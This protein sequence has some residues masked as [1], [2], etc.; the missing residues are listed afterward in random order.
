MII[1]RVIHPCLLACS[2]I[3]A[4]TILPL[5]FSLPAS[6]AGQQIVVDYDWNVGP[7]NPD[8]SAPWMQAIITDITGGVQFDFI[9]LFSS[10][11]FVSEIAFNLV[12]DSPS[13]LST[14]TAACV[15][16]S[17]S[18]SCTTNTRFV[19]GQD[20]QTVNNFMGFDL[21]FF[22]PP[23]QGGPENTLGAPPDAVRF[24]LTG[25]GL[26]VTDFIAKNADQYYTMA[27]IQSI[28]TDPGST[29]ITISKPPTPT[30]FSNGN[31]VPGPLAVAGVFS[32]FAYS[33]KLRKRITHS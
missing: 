24:I 14:L 15:P 21:T 10:A 31:S 5:T 17:G 19:A 1:K 3:S 33:R 6:A 16:L 26:D 4:T 30:T 7:V 22:L 23:P 25:N 18:T 11:N 9:G 27:K 2:V 32:A 13:Y 8:G 20:G 29:S 28:N 12:N